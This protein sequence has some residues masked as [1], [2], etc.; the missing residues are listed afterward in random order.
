MSAWSTYLECGDT[1]MTTSSTKHR[2]PLL[3]LVIGAVFALAII[4]SVAMWPTGTVASND[5]VGVWVSDSRPGERQTTLEFRP[6]GTLEATNLPFAY[7][8]DGRVDEEQPIL[9][10]SGTWSLYVSSDGSRQLLDLALPNP[11]TEVLT[12]AQMDV[13]RTPFGL[14]IYRYTMDPD[15]SDSKLY[16]HRDE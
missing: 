3:W 14:S 13:E 2:L 11:A 5:V 4:V 9:T 15:Q 16:F 7:L 8:S 1:P 12:G 6:D 10:G